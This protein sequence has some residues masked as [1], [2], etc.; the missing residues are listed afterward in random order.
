MLRYLFCRQSNVNV[1]VNLLFFLWWKCRKYKWTQNGKS[2]HLY[3]YLVSQATGSILL[4]P[5]FLHLNWHRDMFLCILGHRKLQCD[6]TIKY[7]MRHK[8]NILL[9]HYNFKLKLISWCRPAVY[10]KT[11]K[12]TVSLCSAICALLVKLLTRWRFRLSYISA[13]QS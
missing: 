1:F 10:K 6:F 11:N 9:R 7:G 5:N 12:C 2:I 4:S 8:E 13:R 3:A